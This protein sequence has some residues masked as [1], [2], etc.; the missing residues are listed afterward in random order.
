M[1]SDASTSPGRRWSATGAIVAAL[2]WIIAWLPSLLPLGSV[3]EGVALG[4]T[5][6]VGYGLGA[7]A[8]AIAH[9]IAGSRTG[10]PAAA[11]TSA[12]APTPAPAPAPTPKR[13]P[14]R[15]WVAVVA[16]VVALLVGL[17]M[18][19]ALAAQA[20]ELG[21][22]SLAP[23]WWLSSLIG[24]V[25][26]A[27]LVAIAR[28]LRRLS[29]WLARKLWRR[30]G[31]AAPALGG[32]TTLV[33]GVVLVAVAVAAMG[34]AFDQIDT[35]EKGQTAPTSSTRSGGPGSL[36]SW[37]SLGHEGRKFVT[38]GATQTTI[39]SFAGLG[40]A[41]TPQAR[42]DLAIEDLLRAG[43]ATKRTWVVI[44][45]TGN[46]QID[47]VAAAAAETATGGDVALVATQYSTLPSWLS[48][49][50]DG[51]AAGAA[52]EALLTS[53]NRARA[54]LPASSRPRLILYGESLGA[55]GSA[56]AFQGMTPEQVIQQ[57][58]GALWV[59]P[60]SSAQP[61][62]GWTDSGTPPRW[63]PVVGGGAVVRYAATAAAAAAPPGD[64]P[65]GPKRILVLAN[66]TD[67][68]VYF[69]G[70]LVYSRPD[71][72]DEP[73]GPGVAAGTAWTPLLFYL[74]VAFDL[75]PAVGMPAGAGHDYSDALP[76][77]WRQ[78]LG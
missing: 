52:G 41:A 14:V 2:F 69:A 50:T 57:V 31:R 36:I 73:R 9:R 42:A 38:G 7:A 43:G 13:R 23:A 62:T 75:P 55:N 3:I 56:Q 25:V 76:A 63:Q 49:L 34:L 74:A 17:P 8:S 35:S 16:V 37:S 65:W 67:P 26:V 45:T 70:G 54:A 61:I 33:A 19:R 30:T 20:Q 44:S 78:V 32:V 15:V 5:A 71:W 72:L 28:G 4:T 77:A 60:P 40:S 59:G 22:P 48:F 29:R 58:D 10:Q 51:A 68:V 1:S 21:S 27:L 66:P 46:G 53:A 47:P 11:P 6:A 64:V 18:S 12:A 24:L 39:R